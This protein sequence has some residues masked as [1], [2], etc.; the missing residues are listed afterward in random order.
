MPLVAITIV[1]AMTASAIL[2]FRVHR[3][4]AR[5]RAEGRA[6]ELVERAG[7]ARH[8]STKHGA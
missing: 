7:L 2:A 8:V 5:R 1:V 6:R 3:E 4:R